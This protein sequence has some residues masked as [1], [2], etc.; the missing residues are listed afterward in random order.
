VVKSPIRGVLLSSG[1]CLPDKRGVWQTN[2][3]STEGGIE[4]PVHREKE[5]GY[6]KV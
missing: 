4:I 6:E 1:T 2:T 3:A 5:V